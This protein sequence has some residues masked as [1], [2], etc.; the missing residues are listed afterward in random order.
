MSQHMQLSSLNDKRHNININDKRQI[1]TNATGFSYD[2][3]HNV[4]MF[5]ITMIDGKCRF[6]VYHSKG[7]KKN[8]AGVAIA[9]R[10][11]TSVHRPTMYDEN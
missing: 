1:A 3:C 5:K 2:K 10:K 4:T 6:T 7:K 11:G 9:V 8:R